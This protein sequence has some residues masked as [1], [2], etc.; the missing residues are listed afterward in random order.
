MYIENSGKDDDRDSIE[1]QTG[2]CREYVEARPYLNL[3][4][5][6]SDNGEKGWKFD[7]PEF[8]RLMDDVRSGR[9]NC[10]VVKDLSRFSRDYIETGN[11]LHS[12]SGRRQATSFRGIRL[13]VM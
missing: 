4:G 1:N 10:I 6:Y 7:R 3:Y 13:M 11:S 2:I 5:V 9:V 8:T 12:G